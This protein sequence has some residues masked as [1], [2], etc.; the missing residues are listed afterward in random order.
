MPQL[1]VIQDTA[2]KKTTTSNRPGGDRIGLPAGTKLEIKYA[3]RVGQHCFVELVQPLATIG[4]LGY[5]FLPHVKVKLDEIRGVWLT[6]VDSSVL[7]SRANLEAALT[8]LKNLG[9]NTLYPVVWNKGFTLYPSAIAKPFVGASV[10]PN[11]PFENRDMLAELIALARPLGFRIIP[12]FEYGLM[13]LPGSQIA[14]QHPEWITLDRNGVRIRTKLA[15]GKPDTSIWMNPC[16]PGVQKFITSLIS[17]VAQKYD[18]DGIQLDDHF[19]F[20]VE[21][22]YD[23]FTQD[24]FRKETG[25]SAPVNHLDL[26][27]GRWATQ[28]VTNLLLQIFRAVKTKRPQCIIS[29]APSPLRFS[30]DNYMAD[31]QAWDQQ[32]LMEEFVVQIYRDQLQAFKAELTKPEVL[33][34]RDRIPATIGLI[35]GQSDWKITTEMMRSQVTTVR[36][37]AFSGVAFFFYETLFFQQLRPQKVP[38][39]LG[40]VQGLFL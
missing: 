8:R 12:W 1:T 15:D 9:C 10:F 11:S 34:M 27:W 5:F 4:R 25:R 19:G 2:F 23:R 30:K 39:S 31:W 18:I 29:L 22:G 37:Q 38:R 28:K 40:E 36:S 32:G 24:L 14:A 7:N 17:E 20:P 3:Y 13:L 6:N 21:L 26:V 33:V 35:A 16:H